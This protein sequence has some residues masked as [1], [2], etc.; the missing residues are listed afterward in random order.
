MTTIRMTTGVCTIYVL[1]LISLYFQFVVA[2]GDPSPAISHTGAQFREHI[3][4]GLI[5]ALSFVIALLLFLLFR[6]KSMTAAWMAV[7]GALLGLCI[8]IMFLAFRVQDFIN[9]FH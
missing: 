3:I 6:N 7:P 9:A 4:Q 1:A 5:L 2:F 8:P